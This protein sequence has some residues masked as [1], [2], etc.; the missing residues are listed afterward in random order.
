MWWL[1]QFPR[2]ARPPP[3]M[4]DHHRLALSMKKVDLIRIHLTEYLIIELL[5]SLHSTS[6]SW[7]RDVQATSHDICYCTEAKLPAKL[8]HS[9]AACAACTFERRKLL[10]DT[11]A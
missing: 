7:Q 6:F 1:P 10:D 5:C 4:L 11:I 8:N 2:P 9:P 3:R